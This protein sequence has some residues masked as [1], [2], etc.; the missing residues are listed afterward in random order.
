MFFHY[1]LVT[2]K[3]ALCAFGDLLTPAIFREL[4]RDRWIKLFSVTLPFT[5]YT[6]KRPE[7]LKCC[8]AVS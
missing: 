1:R 5:S 6:L 3:E 7:S 4:I 2:A 8:R